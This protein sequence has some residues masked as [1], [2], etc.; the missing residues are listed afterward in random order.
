[1][2]PLVGVGVVVIDDGKVLLG[3]KKGGAWDSHWSLPGGKLDQQEELTACAARELAEE[4]GV[5]ATGK[6]MPISVSNDRAP[7]FD[8][9]SIT[10]GYLLREFKGPVENKEPHKFYSWAWFSMSDL[11]QKLFFPTRRLLS[12]VANHLGLIQPHTLETVP[13]AGA[14][15]ESVAL[16]DECKLP[17]VP[18][19]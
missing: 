1:M 10:F 8:L 12:A 7:D 17:K 4:T 2:A 18:H 14:T 9:H 5:Q 16:L 19:E 3:Q 11:P 13:S 6:F 15:R